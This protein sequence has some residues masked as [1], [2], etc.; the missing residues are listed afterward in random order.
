MMLHLCS[1]EFRVDGLRPFTQLQHLQGLMGDVVPQKQAPAFGG[2]GLIGKL[3]E[4]GAG[5]VRLP[6]LLL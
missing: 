1:D 6:V 2:H 3:S 5:A 4:Q